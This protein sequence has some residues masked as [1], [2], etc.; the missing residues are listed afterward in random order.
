MLQSKKEISGNFAIFGVLIAIAFFC[1]SLSHRV[2]NCL[3]QTMF[4]AIYDIVF[5]GLLAYWCTSIKKRIINKQICKYL[6]I[7][8]VLMIMWIMVRTCKWQLIDKT[9][10]LGRYLWYFFYVP[11]VFIPLFGVFIIVCVDKPDDYK[12]PWALKLLYIPAIMI[13]LFVFTND[14]H[15]L[16]FDFPNGIVNYDTQYVYGVLYYVAPAWFLVLGF[17]FVIMLL[18]KSRAPGSK[19]FQNLPIVIMA[20]G[21]VF[22]TLYFIGAIEADLV[23]MDC[24]IISLLL[25][26][27]IESGLI[28]SNTYYNELFN[29]STI[30]AQ[31]VDNDYNQRYVSRRAIAISP[32]IM[33]R[34]EKQVVDLGDIQLYSRK[35][36]G[37][38]VLWQNN[39]KKNKTI[40]YRLRE[41]Q[42]QLNENNDL[43]KAELEIKERQARIEEKNRL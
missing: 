17:Y 19:W 34:A 8:G 26:S 28:R 29:I 38:Y 37:G 7:V 20:V 3:V 33:K 18:V 11:M 32:Q 39:V 42:E 25:E 13:V 36:S 35:V 12:V 2:G 31:I 15:R 10:D 9:A 16:M 22:W 41:V 23:A 6:L 27:A 14:Y 5:L 24:L 21:L 4:N 43:L 40:M 1:N 30:A